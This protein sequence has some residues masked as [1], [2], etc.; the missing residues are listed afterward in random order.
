MREASPEDS[1][2]STIKGALNDRSNPS[3][4]MVES[5]QFLL[6]SAD[7]RCIEAASQMCV[8]VHGAVRDSAFTLSTVASLV[9]KDLAGASR[10]FDEEHPHTV[11]RYLA[12]VILLDKSRTFLRGLNRLAGCDLVE[13]P[14]LTPEQELERL[15]DTLRRHGKLGEAIL[16]EAREEE[17]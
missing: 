8:S 2:A 14:K 6:G 16:A 11:L 4:P 13:R 17:P 12:A 1:R 7:A 5:D 15:R 9:G 10:A 3:E